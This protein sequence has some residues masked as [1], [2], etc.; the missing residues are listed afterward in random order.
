MKQHIAESVCGFRLP[1][2]N[3]IPNVGLYLEQTTKYINGYLEPLGCMEI[4][5]SMLSNYVKKGLVPNPIKKQ[6]YA[7]HIAYLFFVTISK[8]IISLENVNLLLEM[9]RQS[10]S[11]QQAYDYMCGQ[12]ENMLL[13]I[14][15]YKNKM[16]ECGENESEEKQILYSLCFSIAHTVHLHARFKSMREEK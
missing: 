4:T 10:Y 6:Y 8:T 15:G 1:R 5:T 13:Y 3:E 7:E 9:Q 11:A 2:Y 12:L 16:E 14:F